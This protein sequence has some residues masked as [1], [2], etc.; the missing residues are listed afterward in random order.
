[1]FDVIVVGAGVAG[2]TCVKALLATGVRVL[3]IHNASFLNTASSYAQG[4]ISCAWG[5][6]DSW[7]QHKDDTLL[8]GDGLCDESVVSVFCKEAPLTIQQLVVWGVEFDQINGRFCLTKEGGHS[9]A[10]ILHVKDYTGR[11]MVNALVCSV[12]SHANLTC[13]EGDVTGL[14]QCKVTQ[15]IQGVVVANQ[16]HRAPAVVMATGG[17]ASLFRLATHS[18]HHRVHAMA[19]AKLAGVELG[20]LEFIQFHP[21]VCVKDGHSPLLISEALRGEGAVLVNQHHEPFMK[22]YHPLADLAPRDIVARAIVQE[23]PVFLDVSM[24]CSVFKTRFPTIHAQLIAR[25][26]DLNDPYIPV[27]PIAHYTLGGMIASPNGITNVTGLFAIGECAMTGFHGA[28]RLAS[29][30]LLEGCVMGRLCAQTLLQSGFKHPTGKPKVVRMPPL[31]ITAVVFLRQCISDSMG[32]IRTPES[33]R[34][35]LKRIQ[36]HPFA[37]HPMFQFGMAVIESGLVRTESV[38]GHFLQNTV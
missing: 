3:L 4:G 22:R 21:T 20:G 7:Q 23:S 24:L 9:K 1:M 25:G 13:M 37:T 30:S 8:A 2:L 26:F 34:A 35:N 17:Y 28:N 38:G 11:A 16:P 29:N 10:R 36:N 5:E 32:V 14:L 31:P 19:L 27:T 15:A 12:Q 6:D 33:M 18:V